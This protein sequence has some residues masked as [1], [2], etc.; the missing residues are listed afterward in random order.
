M[1]LVYGNTA[2]GKTTLGTLVADTL[3]YVYVSFGDMLR[4]Y[5]DLKAKLK[6]GEPIAKDAVALLETDK[7]VL[8]GFPIRPAEYEELVARFVVEKA[9]HLTADDDVIRQ[10][11]F[12]RGRGVDTVEYFNERLRLYREVIAPFVRTLRIPVLEIDTSRLRPDEIF[13]QTVCWL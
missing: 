8:S 4:E 6:R 10:R 13:R 11:Y 5:P 9:I 7:T 1:L 3:G 2:T 12:E